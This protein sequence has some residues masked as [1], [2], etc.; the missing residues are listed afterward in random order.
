MDGANLQTC[1]ESPWHKKRL[2]MSMDDEDLDMAEFYE[3]WSEI[4]PTYLNNEELI[5]A[6]EIFEEAEGESS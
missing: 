2:I 3:G 4:E 6:Q 5:I 1:R